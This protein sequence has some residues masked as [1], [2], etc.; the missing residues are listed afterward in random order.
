MARLNSSLGRMSD[1]AICWSSAIWE[2]DEP[3]KEWLEKWA[4]AD[5]KA[6]NRDAG[7]PHWFDRLIGEARPAADLRSLATFLLRASHAR[8]TPPSHTI[9]LDRVQPRFLELHEGLLPVPRGLAGLVAVAKLAGRVL[10][11][12]Q[13]RD[14]TLERLH[15]NGL[16]RDLKVTWP[17]SSPSTRATLASGPARRSIRWSGSTPMA[18][19]WNQTGSN[20]GPYTGG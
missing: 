20:N 1:A 14:R 8:S 15:E 6:S 13:A 7:D 18:R 17:H 9:R 11:L 2:T 5:V 12:A 19:A 3:P 16:R 10:A 4:S